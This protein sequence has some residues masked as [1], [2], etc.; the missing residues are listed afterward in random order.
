MILQIFSAAT[1]DTLPPTTVK[2]WAKTADRAAL[3]L[4][5][6]G[7]DGVAG[8]LLLV[9][10]EIGSAVEDEGVELLETAGVREHG[11]AFAGGL[12][13]AIVL[14]LNATLT[15]TE[16]GLLFPTMQVFELLLH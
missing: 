2:S 3:D 14:R 12:L 13:A 8:E 9:D 15:T 7:D 10:A 6:A 4:G 5:E 1:S 16:C 11:D